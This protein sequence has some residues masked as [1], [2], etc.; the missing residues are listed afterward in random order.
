MKRFA[1]ILSVFLLVGC[2]QATPES[3]A[4]TSSPPPESDVV[5]EVAGEPEVKATESAD[6]QTG[7]PAPPVLPV[8]DRPSRPELAPFQPLADAVVGER[9]RYRTLDGLELSYKIT[10]VDSVTVRTQVMVRSQGRLMGQP[11]EREDP[12]DHDPVAE[13]ADRVDAN[14]TTSAETI[15]AAGQRWPCTLYEDRWTDEAVNYVRRTWVSAAAP[16]FGIVRMQLLGDDKPEAT[17]ELIAA[18]MPH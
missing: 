10:A 1:I 11:T 5:R 7:S 15:S 9:C 14:R 18:G 13:Q 16:V 12:L 6:G 4:G 17:L 3:G 8:S 2:D